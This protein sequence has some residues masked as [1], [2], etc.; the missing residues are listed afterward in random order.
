MSSQEES[1]VS[2]NE[3]SATITKLETDA[4]ANQTEWNTQSEALQT[5]VKAL[6]ESNSSA[7]SAH[8]NELAQLNEKISSLENTS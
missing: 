5:Q 1:L 4:E 3:L 2:I 8:A 7:A 6:E